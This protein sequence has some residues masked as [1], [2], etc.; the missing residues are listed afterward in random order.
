MARV[1]RRRLRNAEG[2]EP[3]KGGAR[4]Q[5]TEYRGRSRPLPDAIQVCPYRQGR[6]PRVTIN[7]GVRRGSLGRYAVPTLPDTG[8]KVLNGRRRGRTALSGRFGA[9]GGGQAVKTTCKG[10]N[11]PEACAK[12]QRLSQISEYGVQST[13]GTGWQSDTGAWGRRNRGA[14]GQG[15]RAQVNRAGWVHGYSWHAKPAHRPSLPSNKTPV[16]H[17]SAAAVVITLSRHFPETS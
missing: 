6:S 15:Q 11:R 14:E 16:A 1:T 2:C 13:E 3:C 4:V 8:I 10:A 17:S 12:V 9:A 5:S 7:G